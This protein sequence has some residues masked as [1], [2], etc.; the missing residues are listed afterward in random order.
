MVHRLPPLNAVRTFEVAG[1]TL[2]FSKA[3]DELHVTHG[4]VSKQ[5]KTLESFLEIDLFTRG[6]TGTQLTSAGEKYLK[7]IQVALN[8]I[9]IA[10]RDIKTQ[11][12]QPQL[13]IQAPSA[14]ASFWLIPMIG[15]FCKRYPEV[16]LEI[17]THTQNDKEATNTNYVI[18]AYPLDN[19]PQTAQL[20]KKEVLH[21]LVSPTLLE[22]SEQKSSPVTDLPLLDITKREG[23]WESVYPELSAQEISQRIHHKFPHYLLGVEAA[24]QGLGICVLPSFLADMV[25]KS[26]D[27][28]R[29]DAIEVK[30]GYGYF[31]HIAPFKNQD[32]SIQGFCQWLSDSLGKA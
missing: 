21:C 22:K 10:T 20:L 18:K 15:G 31:S 4:A 7:S 16:H 29:F 32:E 2:N 8:E 11:E 1:R 3:A 5:I 23:V 24:K 26:G 30:T 12:S 17:I 27:L 9:A 13:T 28:V 14:F 6:K 25:V 19:A